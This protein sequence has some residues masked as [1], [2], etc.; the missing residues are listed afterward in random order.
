MLNRNSAIYLGIK[1]QKRKT[2]GNSINFLSHLS[3]YELDVF[4]S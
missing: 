1:E 2:A 3:I 4:E